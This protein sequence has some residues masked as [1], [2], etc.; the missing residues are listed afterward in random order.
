VKSV[1][2][3]TAVVLVSSGDVDVESTGPE[4]ASELKVREVSIGRLENDR[5]EELV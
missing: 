1:S 2:V 4:V 3:G 5:P